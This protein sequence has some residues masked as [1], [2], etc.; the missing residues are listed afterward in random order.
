MKAAELAALL[1]LAACGKQAG[2][3]RWVESAAASN[4]RADEA[5]ARGEERAASE[6]LQPLVT[7]PPPRGVDP[8]DHRIVL[9]DAC[10]RLV[11]L[12]VRR[13]DLEKGRMLLE[14]CL[15]KRADDLFTANLLV[16][17]GRIDELTGRD[18]Q[19]AKDYQEAMRINELLLARETPRE[20]TP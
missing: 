7:E 14:R 16:L 15:A 9:Q 18:A 11:D 2:A 10:F 1:S 4:R 13:G 5:L 19:A 17:R 12:E 6:A 8:E 20:G 3:A